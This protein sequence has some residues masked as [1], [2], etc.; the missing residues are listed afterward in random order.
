MRNPAIILFLSVLITGC[1]YTSHDVNVVFDQPAVLP[2]GSAEGS[3]I[4]LRVVDERDELDLG[5]R[6]A[7]ISV[8]RVEA[9]ELIPKFIRAVE[10]GFRAKGYSL[11]GNSAQADAELIVALRSLKFLESTGFVT[12]GAEVDATILVEAE[13]GSGDFRNQYRSSDE[14]RQLAISFGAG[15][16]EQIN[17]VINEVLAQ[18]LRDRQLDNFL[19]GN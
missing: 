17:L 9:S 2:F 11:I 16:D 8:A 3:T 12:I 10:D 4:R 13:R 15:I 14:D 19:T 7:G 1:A 6:G 5:R 18:L